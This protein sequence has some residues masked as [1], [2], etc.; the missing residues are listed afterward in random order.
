MPR[1]AVLIHDHPFLHWDL[2]LECGDVARAWR[3]LEEPRLG[4][5]RLQPLP[6][7][8]LFYLDYEGPV[9]GDRGT[10]QRFDAGEYEVLSTPPGSS[11]LHVCLYG[12]KLKTAVRIGSKSA[13]FQ[14]VE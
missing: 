1:F 14:T 9:S 6:D 12:E 13:R 8:R 2:L 5:I 4:E 3:L 11:E 7:H 10:V